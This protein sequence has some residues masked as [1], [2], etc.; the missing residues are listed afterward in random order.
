MTVMKNYEAKQPSYF[1]TPSPQLVHALHTAL[2]Q[3]LQT[4]DSASSTEAVLGARYARHRAASDRVK[5][6]VTERLQ[7][8]QLAARPEC[9]AHSMTAFWLPDGVTAPE[10]LKKLAEKGVVFAG[11]L[12]REVKE[13]YAR[14]GHMGVSVMDEGRGDID[15]ALTALEEAL[16]ELGYKPEKAAA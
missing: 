4:S 3:A 16:G 11:G 5:A 12:H 13:K 10:L 1:A 8:K 14:F 7:L 9:A 2:R 6:H 15:K